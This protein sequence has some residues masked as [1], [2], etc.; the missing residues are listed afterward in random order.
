MYKHN[1]S[2]FKFTSLEGKTNSMTSV[3]LFQK[4]DKMTI[5]SAIYWAD[6]IQLKD[7]KSKEYTLM[8]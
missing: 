7:K 4:A 8:Q 6:L 5:S 1:S 2:G 3:H